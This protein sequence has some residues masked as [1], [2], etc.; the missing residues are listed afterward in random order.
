MSDRAR[1]YFPDRA[2]LAVSL[3][4]GAASG[5][6]FSSLVLTMAFLIPVQIVF[7]RSGMLAGLVAAG[8]SLAVT[9]VGLGLRM[10]KTGISDPGFVLIGAVPALLFLAAL[11]LM[12]A[13]WWKGKLGAFRTILPAAA[14][15]L[16]ALPGLVATI[17]DDSFAREIERWIGTVFA[18]IGGEGYESSVMAA[19]IDPATIA[20]RLIAVLRDSYAATIFMM[21]GLSWM[22][23]NRLSGEGSVGRELTGPVEGYKLPFQAVWVFLGAWTAVLA[24]VALRAPAALSALAWNIAIASAMAYWLQG[25]GAAAHLLKRWKVPRGLRIVL[26]A[27]CILFLFNANGVGIV[28][29]VALTLFGVTETWI[30]YRNLKESENESNT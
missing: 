24:A 21:L 7:G 20:E 23:G 1:G 8:T 5:L 18:A 16:I 3:A 13:R 2:S 6:L 9:V 30:P 27:T 28:A 10:A 11:V 29:A 17:G 15:A 26:A 14:C 22:M 25:F 12:N 4:G 19:T